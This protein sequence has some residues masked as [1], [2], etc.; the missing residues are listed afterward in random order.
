[1]TAARRRALTAGTRSVVG[2]GVPSPGRAGGGARGGT[3]SMAA[4]GDHGRP[5]PGP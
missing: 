3:G 4:A 1:M 2:T 5:W